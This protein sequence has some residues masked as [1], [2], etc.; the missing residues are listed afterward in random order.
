M[1]T[2]STPTNTPTR[3]NI[4][5][6]SCETFFP[7][8]SETERGRTER[9]HRVKRFQTWRGRGRSLLNEL[10]TGRLRGLTPYPFLY[11]FWQK[12][13]P[14]RI[15]GSCKWYTIHLPSLEFYIP[16]TALKF[17]KIL[18]NYKTRTFPW[19]FSQPY[20]VSASPFGQTKITY[21]P[22]LSYT[23]ASENSALSYAWTELATKRYPYININPRFWVIIS[24]WTRLILIVR[25]RW[26]HFPKVELFDCMH[27]IHRCFVAWHK[28]C[29]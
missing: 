17:I 3:V 9:T 19:L 7:S 18:L 13:Y 23:S 22:T 5:G 15:L 25:K 1:T 6:L 26:A 12:R 27:Y 29:K 16:L 28:Y 14:F 4:C 11:Y 10:Y 8:A 2:P 20:N 24:L 21:F